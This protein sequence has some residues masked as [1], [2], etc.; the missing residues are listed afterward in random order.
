MGL[1]FYAWGIGVVFWTLVGLRVVRRRRGGA[2][3]D[4]GTADDS[5]P[6]W[7]PTRR[8]GGF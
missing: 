8:G 3:D 5:G 7:S 4:L 6:R 2:L 1:P